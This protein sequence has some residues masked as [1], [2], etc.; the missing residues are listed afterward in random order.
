MGGYLSEFRYNDKRYVKFSE[1]VVE[2]AWISEFTLYVF[3]NLKKMKSP[4]VTF[5]PSKSSQGT[6]ALEYIITL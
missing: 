5:D 2:I 6:T 3:V 4:R 1:K